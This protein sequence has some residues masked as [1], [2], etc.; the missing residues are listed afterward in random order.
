MCTH[1]ILAQELGVSEP[2][3]ARAV[4]VLK[5]GGFISIEK[6]GSSN[7]YLINRRLVWNSYGGNYEKAR[8]DADIAI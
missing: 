5:D 2:T 7:V 3:I 1:T 6:M 4:K 8:F